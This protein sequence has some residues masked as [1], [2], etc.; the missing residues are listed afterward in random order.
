MSKPLKSDLLDFLR[1]TDLV[2]TKQR[3]LEALFSDLFRDLSI[4]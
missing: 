4:Q 1:R 3:C 2:K